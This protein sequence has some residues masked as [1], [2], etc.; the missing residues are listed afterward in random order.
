MVPRFIFAS[1][2]YKFQLYIYL[3]SLLKKLYHTVD[4]QIAY[5]EKCKMDF[6]LPSYH[7]NTHMNIT[8]LVVD[9]DRISLST[10]SNMLKTPTYIGIIIILTLKIFSGYNLDC[11]IRH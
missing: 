8:V 11:S 4:T 5:I 3:H 7:Q 6:D 9:D 1:K 2:F 10:I